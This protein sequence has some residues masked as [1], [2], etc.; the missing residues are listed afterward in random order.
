MTFLKR[1][2]PN[3]G[4][5]FENHQ[6]F[7]RNVKSS[8]LEPGKKKFFLFFKLSFSIFS[9]NSKELLLLVYF[10]V[11]KDMSSKEFLIFETDI[12]GQ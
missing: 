10:D 11:I 3:I 12:P 2:H 9:Q 6:I 4:G 7:H 8:N 1:L 5:S